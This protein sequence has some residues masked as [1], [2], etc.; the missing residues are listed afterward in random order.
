MTAPRSC[1]SPFLSRLLQIIYQA[2][3][4]RN[5]RLVPKPVKWPAGVGLALALLCPA[6]VQGIQLWFP[7]QVSVAL[8]EPTMAVVGY[9]VDGDEEMEIVAGREDGMLVMVE[10]VGN[11]Q[12]RPVAFFTLG[13]VVV[14]LAVVPGGPLRS[15]M[16]VALTANPDRAYLL[17]H[18]PGPDLFNVV[19]EV[20]L[21]EDPGGVAAGPIGPDG[22]TAL[23]VIL[24]GS[25]RWLLLGEVG[26][27]WQVLQE[28]PCGDRPLA[29]ALM[30]LDGDEALEVITADSGVLSRSFS[31]FRQGADG[32]FTLDHQL[33]ALGTPVALFPFDQDGDDTDELFV[34]YADSS[35]LTVYASQA[36]SLVAI[37]QLDTPTTGNGLLAAPMPGGQ[38]GLW[39]WNAERG[40]VLY[41]RRQAGAWNLFETYYS[42]GQ[43]AD[44]ALTDMNGD[45]LPDLVVAN[46]PSASLALLFGNDAYHFRAYLVTLLP[47]VPTEGLVFDENLDGD[48]DFL[49]ACLGGNSVELLHSDGYGHLERDSEP[50]LLPGGPRALTTILADADTL[51]DLAVAQPSRRRVDVLRRLPGG[52]YEPASTV[53]T[54][55]GPFLVLAGDLDDDGQEDLV[56]GNEG[57][58]EITLAYGAPEGTFPDVESLPLLDDLRGVMIADLSD[59]GLPDIITAGGVSRVTTLTNLG[60]RVFGQVRFYNISGEPGVVAKADFDAD[61]DEDLVVSLQAGGALAFLENLGDGSLNISI[62]EHDLS[63]LPGALA[64]GDIDLNGLP[65]VVVVFPTEQTIG[66]VLNFGS[67][68][69]GPPIV[70]RSAVEPQDVDIG[71]FN[72]DQVPDIVILDRSLRL[73]L[74]ML[75][76]EPNPVPATPATL[77]ATCVAS[78]IELRFAPPSRDAWWLEGETG[79]GW[80][81]LVGGGVPVQGTLTAAEAL[82]FLSLSRSEAV[83]A[84][85]SGGSDGLMAFRLVDVTGNAAAVASLSADCLAGPSLSVAPL[86]LLDRPRPNPFNPAVQI[87]FS[88][89]RPAWVDCAIWDLAGRR[90]VSLEN[91]W[92]AAGDFELSWDGRT[93]TGSAAAG[94][95]LLTVTAAGQ[96]L[97][98]KLTLVK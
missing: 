82:W 75:N 98:R 79:A 81:V 21:S 16:L 62:P 63:A 60:N 14:E 95:Y 3:P 26:G 59:D 65:D 5:R 1:S 29:V 68:T 58:D 32:L 69:F 13:G 24:P 76:I 84:G 2:L 30:D 23:A 17:E 46:G 7:G 47:P 85:L 48:V 15:E 78:G 25:D 86:V 43:A 72:G 74:T 77:V 6:A 50:L 80:S 42:G 9:D 4:A 96:V 83:A 70:Y 38:T 93:A 18:S 55:S 71:D 22:S 39:C 64:T 10:H 67:W 44:I 94:T 41:F 54:G 90:V 28:I 53:A 33:P 91:R 57:S 87:A 27:H 49:A 89:A 56:I 88:L 19:S 36:G 52:G 45:L 51:K 61:G 92:F 73:A 40:V 12:F 31:L 37:D 97:T 8:T 34:S 66:I 20:E 11:G 35:F